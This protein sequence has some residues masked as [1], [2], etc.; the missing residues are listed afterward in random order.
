MKKF[1]QILFAAS[2]FCSCGVER[3][4]M[5]TVTPTKIQV[6]DGKIIS[7]EPVGPERPMNDSLNGTVILLIKEKP[8][9]QDRSL[10]MPTRF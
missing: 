4:T 3:K 5:I 10:R 1:P 6:K 8:L 9:S 7:M 2:I